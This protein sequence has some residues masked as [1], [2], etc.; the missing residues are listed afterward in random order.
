MLYRKR[1]D[2]KKLVHFLMFIAV[3]GL[4]CLVIPFVLDY[5]HNFING[6]II[7]RKLLWDYTN[8]IRTIRIEGYTIL[9]L[10]VIVE[11]IGLFWLLYRFNQGNTLT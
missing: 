2:N 6:I 10:M 1:T 5:A 8:Q 4:S 9:L 3:N 11:F 7:P